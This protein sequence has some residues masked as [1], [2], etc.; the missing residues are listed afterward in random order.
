MFSIKRYSFLVLSTLLVGF[1]SIAQ[2]L[3]LLLYEKVAISI[4]YQPSS[5]VLQYNMAGI[6]HPW[7]ALKVWVGGIRANLVIAF[8]LS[9]A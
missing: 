2:Y 8:G 9:L 5:I 3:V 6:V 7:P 1:C 4:Q